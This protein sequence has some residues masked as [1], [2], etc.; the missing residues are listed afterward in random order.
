MSMII[1]ITIIHTHLLFDFPFEIYIS[2]Y[3]IHNKVWKWHYDAYAI[4]RQL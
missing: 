2:T 1:D 4:F 3:F